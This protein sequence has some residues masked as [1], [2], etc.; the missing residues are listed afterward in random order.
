[1]ASDLLPFRYIIVKGHFQPLHNLQSCN[2][3]TDEQNFE[4]G[5][6]P[7][8]DSTVQCTV[9]KCDGKKREFLCRK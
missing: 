1:M 7:S 5:A 8:C 4:V 2:W 6:K 3:L 9:V